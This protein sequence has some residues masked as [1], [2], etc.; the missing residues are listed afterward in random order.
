MGHAIGYFIAKL[1]GII[2]IPAVVIGIIL[3]LVFHFSQ[4]QQ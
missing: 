4:K 1:F 2:G 3:L